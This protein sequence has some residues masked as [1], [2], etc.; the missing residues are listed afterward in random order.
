[1]IFVSIQGLGKEKGQRHRGTEKKGSKGQRH[2]GTEGKE[3]IRG[4][5]DRGSGVSGQGSGVR[6]R[7]WIQQQKQTGNWSLAETSCKSCQISF[8][9]VKFDFLRVHH[10]DNFINKLT[11]SERS[12]M[13]YKIKKLGSSSIIQEEAYVVPFRRNY[14]NRKITRFHS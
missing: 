1:M 8:C 14:F 7:G 9:V 2:I 10:F 11:G 13:C 5:R 3:R 12:D 6:S 4:V